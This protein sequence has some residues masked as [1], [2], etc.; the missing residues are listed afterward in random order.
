MKI[1]L[2][3]IANSLLTHNGQYQA[4]PANDL[5]WPWLSDLCGCWC[6]TGRAP[7]WVVGQWVVVCTLGVVSLL[8]DS[9]LIGTNRE[10][11]QL[12]WT[13][14]VV[15]VQADNATIPDWLCRKRTSITG[16]MAY[17]DSEIEAFRLGPKLTYK[18]VLWFF[19]PLSSA[20]NKSN[21]PYIFDGLHTACQAQ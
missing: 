15:P 21:M 1:N 8:T 3:S 16:E 11:W 13:L 18:F 6:V 9:L 19:S 12:V 4:W 2:M 5:N 10:T 14:L 17:W 7:W 20:G